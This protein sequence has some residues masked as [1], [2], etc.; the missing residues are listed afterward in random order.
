MVRSQIGV[1]KAIGRM[2]AFA[3]LCT[4]G[5]GAAADREP[6]PATEGSALL[7]PGGEDV[8]VVAGDRQRMLIDGEG[9]LWLRSCEGVYAVAPDRIVHYAW[10]TTPLQE[11]VREMRVDAHNRKWFLGADRSEESVIHSVLVIERGEWRTALSLETMPTGTGLNGLTIDAAGDAWVTG[12][13]A[14]GPWMQRLAPDARERVPL[15]DYASQIAADADGSIWVYTQTELMHWDGA[16]WY[17]QSMFEPGSLRQDAQTGIVWLDATPAQRLRWTGEH[18]AFEP[19]DA[20]L[21]GRIV[22]FDARGE[23]VVLESDMSEAALWVKD[24][25][26]HQRWPLAT[27]GYSDILPGPDGDVFVLSP[28]SVWRYMAGEATLVLEGVPLDEQTYPWRAQSFVQALDAPSTSVRAGDLM[29]PSEQVLGSKIHVTGTVQMAYFS[30]TFSVDGIAVPRTSVAI[31]THFAD[32]AAEKSLRPI[33]RSGQPG[34][35]ELWDFHGYLETGRCYEG[36]SNT[37]Q[38]WVVEAY[39]LSLTEPERDALR[40]ALRERAAEP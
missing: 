6:E 4:L 31:A 7:P 20:P 27:P 8:S 9:V 11:L 30:S 24:G 22:G 21:V 35:G 5:C 18:I 39:P 10:A 13:D 37:R 36:I 29:T 32:F 34:A 26:E 15:P 16:E 40:A 2:L 23:A 38:L 14:S 25:A 28:R 19:I 17:R 1:D 3:V 12:S 33:V